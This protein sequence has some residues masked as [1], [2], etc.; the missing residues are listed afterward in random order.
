[1]WKMLFFVSLT[2]G[3][4]L[5]GGQMLK[6]NKSD[7]SCQE[8]EIVNINSLSFTN[9]NEND[10]LKI[11][12]SDGTPLYISLSNIRDITFSGTGIEKTEFFKKL[13]IELVSNYPNPFNNATNLNF[14]T[15]LAGKVKV[16]VFNQ[17]GQLVTTLY[18]GELSSGKH[19]IPWIAEDISTG[20]YI[21][22]VSQNEE[23][24]VNKML[25]LK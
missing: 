19:S 5:H 21:F 7:N 11:Y 17:T 22:R 18:N 8:S 3:V 13:G 1:M 24:V 25:Y 14:T 23:T 6:I 20:T 12:K 9:I 10:K 2:S 15:K 4:L 16:E